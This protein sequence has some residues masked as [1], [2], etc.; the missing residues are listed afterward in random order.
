MTQEE[1]IEFDRIRTARDSLMLMVANL[2]GQA[3][4][5]A[6]NEREACAKV[7]D[8]FIGGDVIAER[9]RARGQA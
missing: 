9:I 1:E 5:I 4:T 3:E 2:R 7:A 8:G 6:A